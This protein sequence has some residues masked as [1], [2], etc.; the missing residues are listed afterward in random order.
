MSEFSGMRRLRET[1]YSSRLQVAA[2]VSVM[3]GVVLLAVSSFLL[4]YAGIHEIVV[5]AGVSPALARLYPLI[6]DATLVVACVATL[7]LRGAAWWMRSFA[8]LSV[9]I[10]LALVAVVEAVH[11]AGVSLPQRSMAAALAA[12]PWALFL[13]GFGLWL[14]MLRHQRTVGAVVRPG[15]PGRGN[16][17][18]GRADP[19]EPVVNQPCTGLGPLTTNPDTPDASLIPAGPKP[20]STSPDQDTPEVRPPPGR[21]HPHEHRHEHGQ[22]H[23]HVDSGGG[24]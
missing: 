19:P 23:K 22:A 24:D 5:A 11:A 15:D 6:F 10:L 8:A 9:M 12:M 14:S 16:E 18:A 17:S 2:V 7:A 21:E 13:L 4:S 3:T 1:D 20:T